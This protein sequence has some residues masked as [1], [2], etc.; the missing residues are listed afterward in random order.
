MGTLLLERVLR[1]TDPE[2]QHPA[3]GLGSVEAETHHERESAQ[4]QEALGEVAGD[5]AQ[6]IGESQEQRDR[7][8]EDRGRI[9]RRGSEG[10]TRMKAHR[11]GARQGRDDA[12]TGEDL[13]ATAAPVSTRPASRASS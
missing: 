7:R 8:D 6:H 9:G 4:G 13:Q 3:V 5:A 11:E 10:Q 12:G 2:A 1:L